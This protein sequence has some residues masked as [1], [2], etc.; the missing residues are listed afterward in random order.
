MDKEIEVEVKAASGRKD[1]RWKYAHLLNEIKDTSTL[2]C[3]FCDKVTKG[4]IYK[5]KQH[6][7]GG[8]S[9]SKKSIRCPEQVRKEIE[10]Y[11]LA[12][13]TYKNQMSFGSHNVN[14]DMF[15]FQDEDNEDPE[16]TSKMGRNDVSSGGSNG[17]GSG[18]SCI[19]R[20]RQKGLMDHFLT[21]IR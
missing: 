16:V 7:V 12:K 20:K 1:P 18:G 5:Q 11:M 19:K 2:N 13:K 17:G 4:S 8:F 6:L 21:P 14:E 15:G 3:I 10:D 9:N